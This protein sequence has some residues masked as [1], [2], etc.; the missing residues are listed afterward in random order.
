MLQPHRQS[1]REL[2]LKLQTYSD[3]WVPGPLPK[4]HEFSQLVKL[5]TNMEMLP[6]ILMVE[7]DL[8]ATR[9]IKNRVPLRE[10]AERLCDYLP[11]SLEHLTLRSL[12]DVLDPEP[13]DYRQVRH[14]LQKGRKVLPNFKVVE[15]VDILS[16]EE[17]DDW[18]SEFLRSKPEPNVHDT[19]VYTVSPETEHPPPSTF[20][21]GCTTTDDLEKAPILKWEDE[22]YVSRDPDYLA[23]RFA[24]IDAIMA[25]TVP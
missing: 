25:G 12:W 8:E 14:L 5:D 2:F 10:Q 23:T 11:P 9:E 15:L 7:H 20:I 22:K 16:E 4:L 18:F 17:N 1:L 6:D 19:Y 13:W 21:P 3:D 24:E